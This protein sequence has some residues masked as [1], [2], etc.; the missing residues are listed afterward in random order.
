[1]A[2]FLVSLLVASFQTS[3]V[4]LQREPRER[5]VPMDENPIT[6]TVTQGSTAVLPCS[7]DPSYTEQNKDQYKVVWVSPE[8]TAISIE[9]RRM[10]NDMRISVERPFLRDWNLHIRN[11]SIT[12]TGEFMCQL[13]TDPVK[14]KSVHL[15]VNVPPT[16]V[17]YTQ[18]VELTRM[19]G[20][21]IEL[22]CN[23]TGVPKPKVT[24]YRM[25]RWS[26]ATRDLVGS[27]GEQLVIYNVTRMCADVYICVAENGVPPATSQEFIVGVNYP[28]EIKLHNAR[29]GQEVG[30]ETILECVIS[31]SPQ[32]VSRWRRGD[33]VL[34]NLQKD[35]YEVNVYDDN[36]EPN[37]IVLSLRIMRV[38]PSDYGSYICEAVNNFGKA[39]R[40]ME[41]YE[42]R[43]K[44]STTTT[45][46]TTTSAS[47]TSST[48]I[49]S[50][51]W[52]HGKGGFSSQ[53]H[54][55]NNLKHHQHGRPDGP[56]QGGSMEYPD[57]YPGI[58][59]VL[60]SRDGKAGRKGTQ[61]GGY[62]DVGGD[63][64]G[65]GGGDGA[66]AGARPSEQLGAGGAWPYGDDVP[67]TYE[68]TGNRIRSSRVQWTVVVLCMPPF[69][70]CF[71]RMLF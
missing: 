32:H 57:R 58:S 68:N 35:K 50:R 1:M 62:D 41:L 29:I 14:S 3:A 6:I 60:V 24:W 47:G 56:G 51:V 43:P 28:P 20:E 61:N 8:R 22:F 18:P 12:D 23:A 44:Q 9:D 71:L 63:G 31:A 39:L 69:L 26:T 30:K 36:T 4:G 10:I 42:V 52:D 11:V 38:E 55:T 25:N 34:G 65:V 13:N 46:T 53:H 19:E 7:V 48:T 21:E 27:N 33:E 37:T 16:I 49:T 45:T 5:V 54:H 59:E 66:G 64:A 15:L 67:G 70:L 2:L 40:H 17:E